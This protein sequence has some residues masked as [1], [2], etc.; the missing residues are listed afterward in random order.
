MSAEIV[1]L[2]R[3]RKAKAREKAVDEAAHNRATHGRSKAERNREAELAARAKSRLDGHLRTGASD[4]GD[5]ETTRRTR[6]RAAPASAETER[7]D[8]ERADAVGEKPGRRDFGRGRPE[9]D[10][11][12]NDVPAAI[13]G[14]RAS[15]GR[16]APDPPLPDLAAPGATSHGATSHGANSHDASSHDA[17]SHGAT[18]HDRS[19]PSRR[20][21]GR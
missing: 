21:D 15:A 6:D 14:D 1:N 20:D 17:T 4:P 12:P 3:A 18:V 9:D 10:A 11:S 16:R 19:P 13:G 8:A 5:P 2:R 7:A